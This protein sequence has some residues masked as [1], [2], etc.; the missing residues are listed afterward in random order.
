MHI[1]ASLHRTI[2]RVQTVET[3]YHG[4][5]QTYGMFGNNPETLLFSGCD[6]PEPCAV[7][8]LRRAIE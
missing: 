6:G 8:A 7:A 4:Y 1:E 5:D 3:S 2:P